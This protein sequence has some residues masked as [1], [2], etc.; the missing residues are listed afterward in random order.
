MESM[1]NIVG[2]NIKEIRE[3]QGITQE[4]LAIKLEM[5]GWRVDRFIV[6]RI[7]RGERQVLDFEVQIIAKVLKVSVSKVFGEKI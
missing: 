7:E 5:A 6:S 3:N 4:Q 2:K 1:K